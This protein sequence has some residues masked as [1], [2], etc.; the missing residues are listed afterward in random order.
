MKF[1]KS[2]LP[3][4]RQNP[5]LP[6][7]LILPWKRRVYCPC[8]FF[9]KHC[10]IKLRKSVLKRQR[11]LKY[12][13]NWKQ[14]P[15][16]QYLYCILVNERDIHEWGFETSCQIFYLFYKWFLLW[17]VEKSDLPDKID[18]ISMFSSNLPAHRRAGELF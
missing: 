9:E 3:S 5:S 14:V 11:Y 16:N 13:S 12:S 2:H 6:G 8:R 7:V 4:F 17:C 18:P 10:W 1:H 15:R